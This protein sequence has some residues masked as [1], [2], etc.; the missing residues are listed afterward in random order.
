MTTPAERPM[1][2]FEKKILEVHGTPPLAVAREPVEGE[3]A[4]LAKFLFVAAGQ[5]PEYLGDKLKEA[6]RQLTSMSSRL[7]APV[8]EVNAQV[9]AWKFRRGHGSGLSFAKP[10][11]YLDEDNELAKPV[12]LVPADLARDLDRRL[13]EAIA[14]GKAAASAWEQTALA[15]ESKLAS[16]VAAERERYQSRVE[17]LLST[18]ISWA[19]A[20]NKSERAEA[21]QGAL[22]AIRVE[23][24]VAA[25]IRGSERE[26]GGT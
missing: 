8:P 7:T 15:A 26:G 24:P 25:A 13:A 2:N 19:K 16:A 6:A 12:A 5:H 23:F 4:A 3:V 20:A 21:L 17:D 11:E 10:E 18:G 22:T 1:S 9:V 14:T